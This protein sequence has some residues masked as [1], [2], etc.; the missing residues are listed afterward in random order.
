MLCCLHPRA[1][2]LRPGAAA[3]ELAILLPLM[4]FLFVAGVDFARV[5]YHHLTITNCARNGAL[6]GSQ[7]LTYAADTAGIEAAALQ[8]A[9][10]LTP[11]PTVVSSTGTNASGKPYV[12]VTVTYS[13]QMIAPYPGL[14]NP[15]T[16]T[17]TI[18]M[19]V[20]PLVPA[21]S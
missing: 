10:N 9:T 5:F 2:G 6:Y 20:A 4:G 16:I 7:D 13:F 21:N 1:R 3:T 12:E 11:A 14:P 15:F 18:Q 17:R 19:R 8:D